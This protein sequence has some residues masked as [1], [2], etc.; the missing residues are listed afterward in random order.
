MKILAI[1]SIAFGGFICFICFICFIPVFFRELLMMRK[2]NLLHSFLF[3]LLSCFLTLP[4]LAQEPPLSDSRPLKMGSVTP[5]NSPVGRYQKIEFKIDLQGTFLSPFDPREIDVMGIF[6]SPSGKRINGPAFYFQDY[7]RKFSRGREILKQK[8]KAQWRLRF[9][10]GEVGG[11]SLKIKARDKSGKTVESAVV[12]FEVLPSSSPGFIRLHPKDSRYFA[13]DSGKTYIPLGANVCWAGPKGTYDYDQWLPRYGS[14]GATF[15]RVWLGPSWTTFALERHSI[16][17]FSQVSSYRLDYVLDLA[18]KEGLYVMLCFDSYNELRYKAERAFA[19]WDKTP[20]NKANGGP[21][22]RPVQ[23]WDKPVMRRLYQNKL[24]YLVAR[25]GADT[26][27]MAWE[28]W[29]EVDLVSPFA[30]HPEKV[31][32]WHRDMSRHLRRLDPY[33]HLHST[34]FAWSPGRPYIDGLKEMD[35]VQTHQYGAVDMAKN[36][37]KWQGEKS[38]YGKPHIIGEFGASSLGKDRE[39]DPTGI[40]LHNGLWAPLLSGSAG[41]GMVWWWD[42]H[43]EPHNLYYHLKALSRFIRGV[44][45]GFEN[46]QPLSSYVFRFKSSPPDRYRDLPLSGP[47]S[48]KKSRANRPTIVRIGPLEVK[49]KGEVAGILHGLTNHP[50]K[51]NPLTLQMNLP[52]GTVIH[53]SVKG[54]SGYGGAHLV[55]KI[56]GQ[57]IFDKEMDDPDGDSSHKTLD[58]HNG[59]YSLFIPA[60]KHTVVIENLGKDWVLVNYLVEKALF[61]KSP[62]LN[63]YGLRGKGVTLLWIQNPL[64]TWE[65]AGKGKRAPGGEP[66]TELLLPGFSG[67]YRVIYW[68]TYRGKAIKTII[69]EASKNGLRVDLPP[70]RRDVALR[71]ERRG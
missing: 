22:E 40:C 37:V 39:V 70:I 50:D 49:I 65:L 10:P 47:V 55:G 20:H 57:R 53:I 30:F 19:Y 2:A 35:F 7:E 15:F 43:I 21:L 60:G 27:V 12:N 67:K 26:H 63:L 44:D 32:K 29:N 11:Y 25:W 6:T 46:F 28:F 58:Q 31:K 52:H 56:D 4:T 64:H 45:F 24:R 68:D 69:L 41:G 38:R 1:L 42:N 8:G 54:V 61:K 3:L 51:H 48:W 5:L 23:F 9:C 14:A 13:F 66:A 34:S 62:H 33:K 16:G 17:K 36:L 18:R 59:K 71:I